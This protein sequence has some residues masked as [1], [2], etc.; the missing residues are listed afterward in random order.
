MNPPSRVMPFPRCL[1]TIP[2]DAAF[3]SLIVVSRCCDIGYVCDAQTHSR[4]IGSLISR[5]IQDFSRELNVGLQS[6]VDHREQ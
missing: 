1:L 3:H 5:E 4:G 2:V 6:L